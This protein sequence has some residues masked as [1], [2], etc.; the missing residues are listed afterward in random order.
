MMDRRRLGLRRLGR[1][2]WRPR[3]A[4]AEPS[5]GAAGRLGR[6]ERTVARRGSGRG[7][8]RRL[9]RSREQRLPSYSR[10]AV[11]RPGRP[12]RQEMARLVRTAGVR[13]H[14]RRK[15]QGVQEFSPFENSKFGPL[16][17][18]NRPNKRLP[19]RA[20]R[21]RLLSKFKIQTYSN[22]A[23]FEIQRA[24]NSSGGPV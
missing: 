9:W 7:K 16:G 22:F 24:R 6:R 12:Q 23:R 11:V 20:A 21:C 15:F 13:A 18:P 3:S 10:C 2:R 17:H 5:V 1:R 14:A 19:Y 4:A 8:P